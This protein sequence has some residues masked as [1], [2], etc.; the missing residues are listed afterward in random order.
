MSQNIF[1][2]ETFFEG[3]MDLREGLNYNDLL[4]QPAMRSLLPDLK[5]KKI[6]DMGCG[7]GPVD[8]FFIESGAESV[9]AI[10]ISKKMLEKAR[11][12]NALPGIEY[13]EMSMSEI[14]NLK[15]KYDLVFSS[16][17][18]HYIKNFPKLVKDVHNILNDGGVFLFSQEHPIMTASENMEGYFDEDG[19][20]C[21]N[22][23][24]LPGKRYGKWFVKG[25]ESYHR[26][27]GELVTSLGKGGFLITDMVE[28]VPDDEVLKIFPRAEHEFIRPTFLLIKAQ[29]LS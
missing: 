1:D 24:L 11:R 16:L 28:P 29:K 5:G 19:N 6:L 22:S 12:E 21:M 14:N 26:T 20:Y 17:A 18:I 2:N 23:Y 13:K 10:D 8:R 4:E 25:V 7:Y 9:T 3:Y 15:G 27:M